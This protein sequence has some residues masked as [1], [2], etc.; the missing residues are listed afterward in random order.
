MRG[1]IFVSEDLNKSYCDLTFQIFVGFI[2]KL[3]TL[4][5]VEKNEYIIHIIY[6]LNNQEFENI[7]FMAV[8]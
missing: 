5:V 2:K 6:K 4:L 3:N 8:Y 1:W 7:F